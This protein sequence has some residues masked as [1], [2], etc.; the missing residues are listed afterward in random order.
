M[1]EVRRL[2]SKKCIV[3]LICFLIVAIILPCV[4]A[5]SYAP[6]VLIHEGT[7]MDNVKYMLNDLGAVDGV[8]LM[9]N[10]YDNTTVAMDDAINRLENYLSNLQGYNVVVQ[11]IYCFPYGYLTHH[12]QFELSSFSEAFYSEW[13]GKLNACLATYSNIKLFVGF[14]EAYFCF[15]NKDDAKTLMQR[16]YTIWKSISEIPFSC[17][18]TFPFYL[19]HNYFNVTDPNFENDV[20]PIWQNYSDYIGLNL[21]AYEY[22]PT[23]GTN[24]QGYNRTREAVITALY[25]GSLYD[26]P[27]H[28]DEV[29][30]WYPQDFQYVADNLMIQPHITSVYKLWDWSNSTEAIYALYN[31]NPESSNITRVSPTWNVYQQILNPSPTP[32]PTDIP[33]PWYNDPKLFVIVVA[34]LATIIILVKKVMD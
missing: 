9:I 4:K 5:Q 27:V 30:C 29:L 10:I 22:P 8:C 31:I 3:L 12:W 25:Y 21:L 6:Y 11:A 1:S 2:N 32:T 18:I 20:L 13:Y 17:E 7:S 26:K 23:Y 34:V 19:W 33:T 24:P 15:E 28:V 16:E 14:N